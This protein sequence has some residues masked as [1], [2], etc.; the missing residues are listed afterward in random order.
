MSL[1]WVR[2]VHEGE[3]AAALLQ[4]VR[5]QVLQRLGEPGS[6][7]SLAGALGLPR[8]QVNYHLRELERVGLVEFVEERRRGNCVERLYRA[9]AESFV[10]AP[11]AVGGLKPD[12][13]SARDRGSS[14]YLVALG[15]QLIDDIGHL[16]DVRQRV[17]TLAVETSLRFT[18]DASRAAFAE[19]LSRT[20]AILASK[21]HDEGSGNEAYRLMCAV[22]PSREGDKQ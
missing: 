10:I 8:Q 2:I 4:P 1:A 22:H 6:A 21:Y 12:P 19:E 9:V 17:P 7:T 15:A 11:D 5:I 16:R 3:T 18:N 13:A 20:L 14:D